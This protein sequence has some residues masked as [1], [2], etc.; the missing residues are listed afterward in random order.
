MDILLAALIIFIGSFVQSAIGFGLAIVAAPFLFLLSPDYVPAPIT[1]VA[2]LLSIANAYRY[3]SSIS[4]QGLGA[5][6]IGRIPGTVAGGALLVWVDTKSLSLW[7]GV[8]VLIAVA[9]SLL[10]LR[11]APTTPRM[12]IAGFLS[13]FMGTSTAIGG[14]PLALLLQHE[15]ANLIRANLSAFFIVSCILSLLV[16]GYTGYM[17]WHHFILTLPLIPAMLLGYWLATRYVERI[18]SHHIRL[19]SL[20]ICSLSGIGA[21]ALYWLG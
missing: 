15:Q 21:I 18:A 10:P 11:I 7:L 14:P 17:S 9:V 5:A 12:L 6:I 8:T 1:L 20:C 19:V 2:L 13:G 4:L 3:R 16:Q